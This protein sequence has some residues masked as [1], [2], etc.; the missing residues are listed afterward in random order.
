MEHAFLALDLLLED[1]YTK[2]LE[3]AKKLE[4]INR[5][6]QKATELLMKEAEKDFIDNDEERIIVAWNKNWSPSLVGLAAGRF[7]DRFGKPAL[8]IGQHNGVWVGSGRS[9]KGYH[10]TEALK[11]AG[12]DYLLRFGGHPQACGFSLEKEEDVVLFAKAMQEHAKIKLENVDLLPV[13]EI[14]KEIVFDDLDWRLVD[15]LALF[16]PFGEANPKPIFISKK[17]KVVDASMVGAAQNHLRALLESD[18]A[19][20]QKF[21]GFYKTDLKDIFKI[22]NIIDVVYEIGT[23][24]WN[25]RR[26]I[27]CKIIS[28]RLSE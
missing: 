22:G 27:Q 10:I 24:E 12:S 25:G 17:L 3:K 19:K 18:N 21:I 9:I 16:E 14:E 20:K 5:D 6:R 23:S 4:R 8:F 11:E 2:A 1:D 28:A 7:A 13:L 15:N 26:E